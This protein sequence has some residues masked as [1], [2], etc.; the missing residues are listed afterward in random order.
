[1]ICDDPV[2]ADMTCDN[3]VLADMIC[4]NPVLDCSRA[5][6]STTEACGCAVLLALSGEFAAESSTDQC[7]F[8]RVGDQVPW[9]GGG[10]PG[11]C[12]S[13]GTPV[14]AL[15]LGGMRSW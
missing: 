8:G 9:H 7:G 13:A 2:L 11:L 5:P 3:P 1:M 15:I 12:Q 6:P 10:R 4:N 14:A